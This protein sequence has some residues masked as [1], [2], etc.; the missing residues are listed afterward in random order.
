MKLLLENIQ[1]NRKKLRPLEILVNKWKAN[2]IPD[3]VFEHK[4]SKFLSTLFKTDIKVQVITST[5]PYIFI[6]CDIG[7]LDIQSLALV[8]SYGFLKNFTTGEIVAALLHE[9]ANYV[10]LQK[11]PNALK[12]FQK[13]AQTNNIAKQLF[14]SIITTAAIIKK[15]QTTQKDDAN[16]TDKLITN[17]LT[18]AAFILAVSVAIQILIY[19]ISLRRAYKIK[20]IS[21][22]IAT[23]LGYGKELASFVQKYE[24]LTDLYGSSN[25]SDIIH[26]IKKVILLLGLIRVKP[27]SSDRICHIAN[28]ILQESKKY[29]IKSNE[30]IKWAK[31]AIAKYCKLGSK[32]ITKVDERKLKELFNEI[33]DKLLK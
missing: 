24:E 14:Q 5:T 3:S 30:D 26:I 17:I 2:E 21:D 22:D 11:H 18:I 33:Y 8:V 12:Y 15:K 29:N 28:T 16:N 27:T 10:S 25:I 19:I 31:I 6:N 23:R 7:A 9:S 4:T 13:T 20:N 32:S 1:E